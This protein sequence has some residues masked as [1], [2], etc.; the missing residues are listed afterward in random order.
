M[1]TLK[2]VADGLDRLSL[3]L[4]N[5]LSWLAL[6]IALIQTA[7]VVLRYSFGIAWSALQESMIYGHSLLF[8]GCAGYTYLHGGHVRIDIL[9]ANLTARRRAWIDLAGVFLL[10]IPVTV[11]IA[12]ASHG[13]VAAAWQ[14]REVSPFRDGIPALFLLKT[15]IP[16][17]CLLMVLQ[18]I[19]HAIRCALFLAGA[20]A[21]SASPFVGE[22]S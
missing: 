17:F 12:W 13:Y 5:T 3:G 9:Y 4:G 6:A 2:A 11:V 22:R 7:I 15:L 1:R 19:A 21:D 14:I 16:V 20:A 8:L 10:L 18:G